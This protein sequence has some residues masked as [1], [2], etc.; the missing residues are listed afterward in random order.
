M[1][2]L[3]DLKTAEVVVRLSFIVLAIL[4]LLSGLGMFLAK[5]DRQAATYLRWLG[6]W[7]PTLALGFRGLLGRFFLRAHYSGNCSSSV[8]PP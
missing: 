1:L 8:C 5:S 7:R 3:S 6:K 2:R 4:F